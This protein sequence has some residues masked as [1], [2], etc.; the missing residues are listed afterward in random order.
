MRTYDEVV[1]CLIR[2]KW[3]SYR[4]TSIYWS[5]MCKSVHKGVEKGW[6]RLGFMGGRIL[7]VSLITLSKFLLH[8]DRKLSRKKSSSRCIVLM[9]THI[10]VYKVHRA[11]S[12]PT[13]LLPNIFSPL[14]HF[15]TTNNITIPI[16]PYHTNNPSQVAICVCM[17]SQDA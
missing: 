8:T 7:F 4:K 9:P 12:S 14:N 6:T 1:V 13:G 10:Q 2:F 11:S 5:F 17:C 3:M 16:D 15:P